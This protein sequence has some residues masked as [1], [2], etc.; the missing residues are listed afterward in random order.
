MLFVGVSS[1]TIKPD[2]TAL[3]CSNYRNFE[4]TKAVGR[5]C[6]EVDE[7]KCQGAGH[8]DIGASRLKLTRISTN[9]GCPFRSFFYYIFTYVQGVHRRRGTKVTYFLKLDL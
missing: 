8:N 6:L 9:T 2:L 5:K 4:T 3:N 1:Q 7:K